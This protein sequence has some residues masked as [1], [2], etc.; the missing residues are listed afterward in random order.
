V[1]LGQFNLAAGR[2]A[3]ALLCCV[4]LSTLFAALATG[5]WIFGAP[6][7]SRP[8]P[9]VQ[10]A[11]FHVLQAAVGSGITCVF[12]YLPATVVVEWLR[13]RARVRWWLI[14]ALVLLATFVGAALIA[15]NWGKR[16]SPKWM[17]ALAGLTS[18][19]F[20]MGF[21]IYWGI[22]ARSARLV[23]W[24]RSAGS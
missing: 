3:L 9:G 24:L 1:D 19:T 11:L 20:T 4:S 17:L 13:R 5:V 16:L 6:V 21:L 12:V 15:M 10:A 14:A 23:Q 22:A 8:A 7:F 18:I 2:H